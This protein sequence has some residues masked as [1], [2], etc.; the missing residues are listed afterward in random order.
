MGYGG[1]WKFSLL[2]AYFFGGRG[3]EPGVQGSEE[4]PLVPGGKTPHPTPTH[5]ILS[6]VT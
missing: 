1:G 2:L 6:S 4:N 5:I 3:G